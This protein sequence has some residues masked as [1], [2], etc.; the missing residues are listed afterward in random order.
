[1]GEEIKNING[2]YKLRAE[3]S[4]DVSQFI[5][6]AHSQMTAF[7]MQKYKELPDVE[8]EF[9][10]ELALDKIITI[11]EGI[12]DSHVMCETVKPLGEYTGERD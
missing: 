9:E 8:F 2:E 10:T 5:L 12:N 3:C 7:K 6:N 11:L 4:H 1:M